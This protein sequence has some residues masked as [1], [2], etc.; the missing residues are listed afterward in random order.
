MGYLDIKKPA[1]N[2]D[3]KIVAKAHDIRKRQ[4]KNSR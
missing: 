2:I 3:L 4:A 1:L